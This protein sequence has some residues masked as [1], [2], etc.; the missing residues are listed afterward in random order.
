MEFAG[1]LVIPR[2]SEPLAMSIVDA[3]AA[4]GSARDQT[5][6][7]FQWLALAC[8]AVPA[9]RFTWYVRRRLRRTATGLCP[10]CGYNLTGNVSGVCPECGHAASA[11][12]GG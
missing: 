9:F 12:P 5:A 1:V 3:A 4:A 7:R 10:S 8:A 6:V 2:T 11:S